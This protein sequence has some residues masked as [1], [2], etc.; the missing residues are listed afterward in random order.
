[1]RFPYNFLSSVYQRTK[2]MAQRNLIGAGLRSILSKALDPFD[3]AQGDKFHTKL[4]IFASQPFEFT[5]FY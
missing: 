1:M 3:Y 5:I 4:I 2:C